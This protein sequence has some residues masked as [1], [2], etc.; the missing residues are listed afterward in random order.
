MEVN[1]V[2][3]KLRAV[4]TELNYILQDAARIVKQIREDNTS[5]KSQAANMHRALTC[6]Y[7]SDW[8]LPWK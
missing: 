5:W 2:E 3:D 8:E 6:M 1:A 7:I 4:Q